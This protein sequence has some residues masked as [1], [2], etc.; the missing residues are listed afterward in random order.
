[1]YAIFARETLQKMKF[2]GKLAAQAGHAYLH[3][4]WDAEDRLK[5]ETDDYLVGTPYWH[6]VMLP[7]KLCMDARK[8]SLVVDTVADLEDLYHEFKPHMGATL[9]KDCGYTVFDGNTITAVGLGPIQSDWTIG[10]K[11]ADLPTLKN[12][13]LKFDS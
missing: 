13:I 6:N 4:W 7:Y 1:M 2:E 10:T 5:Y 12:E 8:V 11:L 9:V 3:A